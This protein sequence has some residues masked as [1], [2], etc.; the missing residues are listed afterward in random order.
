MNKA[1]T[2]IELLGVI[3]IL[4]VIALITTPII[5]TVLK[6]NKESA[7]VVTV[8]SIIKAAKNYSAVLETDN[9]EIEFTINYTKNPYTLIFKGEEND[10]SKEF[11]KYI[12]N[13]NKPDGGIFHMDD[14][15]DIELKLWFSKESICIVKE[16]DNKKVS[17]SKEITK[18]EECTIK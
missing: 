1:F 16:I 2:L 15:G 5:T 4:A 14:N 11:K 18:K 8:E 7:D 6:D 10:R 13:T 9:E 17:I 3:I 12:N